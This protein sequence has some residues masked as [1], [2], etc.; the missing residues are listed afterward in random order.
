SILKSRPSLLPEAYH[1]RVKM[2]R[3]NDPRRLQFATELLFTKAVETRARV[4]YVRN[5][6]QPDLTVVLQHNAT[7]ESG[8]GKLVAKNRNIFFVHGAYMSGELADSA[9]RFRLLTKLFQDVT[10]TEIDVA[11]HIAEQFEQATG[12]LPVLYGNSANTRLVIRDNP[13]V[14]ARNLAFNREHD[15]PVVVTEPYF[16][17]QTETLVRLLSGD[18]AGKRIVAGKLRISIYRE[19]ANAVA[20]GILATYRPQSKPQ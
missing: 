13:Y 7:P 1:L 4:M 12:Y 19:Y 10:Q 14:V 16:M 9:Q 8:E 15:G 5:H 2:L 17:N 3:P 11:A 18:F 6:F 20:Q